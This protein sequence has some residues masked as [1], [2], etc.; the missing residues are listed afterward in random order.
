MITGDY[1]GEGGGENCREY[2][3]ANYTYVYSALFCTLS[4]GR[5]ERPKYNGQ[6]RDFASV[7]HFHICSFLTISLRVMIFCTSA[8]ARLYLAFF[9]LE[10]RFRPL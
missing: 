2:V 5:F 7:L 10:A 9:V 4:I 3:I 1:G 8:S 6:I